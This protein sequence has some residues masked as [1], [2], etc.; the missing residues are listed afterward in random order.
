MPRR[1]A[2][3]T[4]K[5]DALSE[6]MAAALLAKP[7]YDFHDLFAVVHAS[8]RARKTV[9]GDEDRLRLRLY[10]RLQDWVVQ[11]FVNK[12]QKQYTGVKHLLR[13][14]SSAM[15]TAKAQHQA[16]KAA[17]KPQLETNQTPVGGA[18]PVSTL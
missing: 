1:R 7:S 10:E 11:G 12:T 3:F 15:A 17:K 13:A 5:T 6:E 4:H 14:R 8:F 2:S 18:P 16:W 9:F